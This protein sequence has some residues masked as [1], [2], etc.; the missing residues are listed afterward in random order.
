MKT[1]KQKAKEYHEKYG[2][3]PIGYE[4]RISYMVDKY[5]LSENKMKEIIEKRDRMLSNLFFY[6][7]K[8]VQLFEEPEGSLRPRFRII[9][10]QNFNRVAL[11]SQ[12]VHVYTPRAAEDH[13]YMKQLCEQDLM[14]LDYLINT[15]CIAKY[16]AFYKTPSYFN[17][18]DV[19]LA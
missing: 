4:D 18:T 12:F 2:D 6:E 17:T 3:I 1:R 8:V 7:C 13:T 11:E 19:F 15:P 5:N 16:D 10:K 9:N 14:Q